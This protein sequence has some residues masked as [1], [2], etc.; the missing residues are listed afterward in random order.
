MSF[1]APRVNTQSNLVNVLTACSFTAMH[2]ECLR[3]AA[4]PLLRV[5]LMVPFLCRER[6]L[7]PSRPP[8]PR[9][10]GG[11]EILGLN[12]DFTAALEQTH[13]ALD[14]LTLFKSFERFDSLKHAYMVEFCRRQL[15]L[16]ADALFWIRPN[17]PVR[18]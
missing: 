4:M 8:R 3:V 10:R 17:Q 2:C 9:H 12:M 1:K 5:F 15:A 13:H 7:L 11:T 14:A 16:S 6:W 18:S